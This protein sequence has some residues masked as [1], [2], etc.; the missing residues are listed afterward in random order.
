MRIIPARA[1]QTISPKSALTCASD[2]PRACGA[3]DIHAVIKAAEDGSSPRVRGK[4]RHTTEHHRRQRI[5]PARAGQTTGDIDLGDNRSDHPRACGANF[6]A[7]TAYARSFGSSPR[8]R[9][10]RENAAVEVGLV[11]I[12]PARAGQTSRLLVARIRFSDHPRACGANANGLGV[13]LPRCGSSP[14]VRG[15]P[16]AYGETR[17]ERRIIPAR[18]GQTVCSCRT[19]PWSTDH[20]RACGANSLVVEPAMI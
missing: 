1:G 12:I 13:M 6:L 20:P 19:C 2:H 7:R 9:G 3:N 16:Q 10:K 15:K 5:I 18:A 4:L 14:R 11:R 17:H 8:V